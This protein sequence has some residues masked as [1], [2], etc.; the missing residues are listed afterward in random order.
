MQQTIFTILTNK[1][2]RDIRVV[3]KTLDREFA[4]GVPWFDKARTELLC[5]KCH[6][7][8]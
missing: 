7:A 8:S 2:A 5:A 1:Q 4:V 3:E 6:V